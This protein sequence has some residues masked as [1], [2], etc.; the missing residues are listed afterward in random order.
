MIKVMQHGA[1][2]ATQRDNVIG[3][4]DAGH[5]VSLFVLSHRCPAVARH[6][7]EQQEVVRLE[8]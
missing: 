5:S 4:I 2:D 1:G 8:M 7:G 3:C 6:Q